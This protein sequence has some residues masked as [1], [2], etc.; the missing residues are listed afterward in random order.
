MTPRR[1]PRR[2]AAFSMIEVMVALAIVAILAALSLPSYHEA[3]RRGRRAEARTGLLQAAHWLERVA[4]HTGS[5]LDDEADFPETL[6]G[7]PSNSY[8]IG[9]EA[10]QARGSGYTLTATP[11]GAQVGDRCGGFTLDQAGLR[12]LASASAT[13]ALQAEC[14]NR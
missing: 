7:V 10:S 13:E 14:W 4:T 8:A 5:Y 12:G 9:F 11:R 3:V 6:K 2:T 1:G